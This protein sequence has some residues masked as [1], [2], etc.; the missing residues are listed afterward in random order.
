MLLG[1]SSALRGRGGHANTT[2][3]ANNANTTPTRDRGAH[4]APADVV[5]GETPEGAKRPPASVGA[6]AASAVSIERPSTAKKQRSIHDFFGRY[7]A[8]SS[9]TSNFPTL[10]LS[11]LN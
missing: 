5:V 1:L 10:Q 9:P 8:F 2:N 6:F 7:R 3:S 11:N 4:E